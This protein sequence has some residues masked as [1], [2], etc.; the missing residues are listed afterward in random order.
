ML[1]FVAACSTNQATGRSSFTAFMSPEEEL[2]VGAQE[3]PKI[4]QSYG[5]AYRNAGL[6]A[7]VNDVGQRL[8]QVSELPNLQFTFTVLDDDIVN[9][10]ALPGGY[11]YISRGLVAIAESEAEM[12]GVLAHEI[13][14]VTARHSAER[15]SQTMATNIGLNVI[16]I[17]GSVLGAPTGVNQVAG[18]GAGLALRS[19]S[20]EQELEA[21]MLGV[22]Y[23]ARAGY[24]TRAMGSFFEKMAAND[25]LEARLKGDASAAER[26]SAMSTHPR[27]ADRIAQAVQLA[28][29]QQSD[30]AKLGRDAFLNRIDGMTWGGSIKQG[31]IKG[32]EFLHPDLGFAYSVPD[33][34]TLHNGPTQV[35]AKGPGEAL[36]V[37]DMENSQIAAKAPRDMVRYLGEVWAKSL[38][39]GT[40]ERLSVN[41]MDS[42]T[43][44][45]RIRLKSGQTRDARLIAMRF[46]DNRIFRFLFLTPPDKTRLFNEDFRRTTYSFRRLSAVDAQKIQPKRIQIITAQAG[47][48]Q[49]SLSRYMAFDTAKLERFQ[50]LNALPP[51]APIIPGTKL[52]IVVN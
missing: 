32:T 2:Q 22:R 9:A 13:G 46:A 30:Q 26:F 47:D 37:F 31:V 12:A 51:G 23:L 25:A 35:I 29:V 49:E 44:A 42:S 52:K 10:F 20:R 3:H 50:V 4:L 36:I 33:G 7:Y 43:A 1:S 15:Y 8:A 27:T 45:A 5:G 38:D 14:H 28:A 6:E 17:V 41:G 40:I 34:F 48:T 24:D 19:Y 18:L 11:V 21:D 16:G 39:I